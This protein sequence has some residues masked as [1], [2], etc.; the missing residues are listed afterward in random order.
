MHSENYGFVAVA[1]LISA[2]GILPGLVAAADPGIKDDE[3]LIGQCAALTGPAQG[4]GAGMNAGLKAA[5]D[6]AN[7]KGGI[8]GR[9]IRLLADDD[10][11]DPDKCVDCTARMIEDKGVFALAGYVGTPT[12]KVAAPMAQEDKIPLVGLFTGAMLLRDPVQRYVINIR[13]SYDDETE[14]LVEHL[15]ENR[16]FQKIAVFYQNDSFGF[17]GLSGVEKALTRRK[18]AV[19]GKG[20]FERNTLDVKG[21]LAAVMAGAPDAVVIVAPYEPT[22]AFVRA[23]REAG[24]KAQLAT[25]SFVGTES[26]IAQLGAASEGTIISQVVPSPT[27]TMLTLSRDYRSALQKSAPTASPSYVS[28]EGYVGGRVLVAALD[29]AGKDLSREKLID[30]FHG[31][32]KLELGGMIISF[33]PSN[34]QGSNAVYITTVKDGKAQPTP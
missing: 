15:T 4:L 27:D 11:Y 20:S 9:L 31:M 29:Q 26:L 24:L 12:G 34:H 33:S 13:A 16:A 22:A 19:V 8:H 23:A 3:I 17:S 30:T 6:E 25:I 7:S 5:F 14:A 10:G 32:S 21:G 2:L 28:F 1:A 18:L